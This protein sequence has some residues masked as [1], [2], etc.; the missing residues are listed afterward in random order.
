MAIRFLNALNIDGTITATVNAD[1][2][3]TYTGLDSC[4]GK[5]IIKI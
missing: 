4:I 1:S 3:S 5:W 2:D